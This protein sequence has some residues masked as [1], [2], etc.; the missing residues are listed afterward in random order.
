MNMVVVT[1][2]TFL[3]LPVTCNSA[4]PRLDSGLDLPAVQHLVG[5]DREHFAGSSEIRVGE[6]SG[7][8]DH[9]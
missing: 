9:P 7:G 3:A 6:P 1:S 8:Q 5:T 2:L 4:S